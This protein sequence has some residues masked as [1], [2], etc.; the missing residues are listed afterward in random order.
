MDAEV[1][2]QSARYGVPI[3][4]ASLPSAGATSPAT[5]DG[6]VLLASIEI[7]AQ[8]VMSQLVKP[9]LP[10]YGFPIFFTLDMQSGRTLQSSVES[11]LGAAATVQFINDAFHIPTHTYGFGTD[12]HIPDGQSTIEATLRSLLVSMADCDILGGAGQLDV[13]TAFSPVQLIIDDTLTSILKR[14]SSGVKVD[15]DTLA[16]R[17]ILDT[18]PIGHFLERAHTLKYCREA[19]RPE[20][21]V[22][23]PMELWSTEG[24]KD[25]NTRAVEKYRE[26]KKGLQP[27]QLPEDVQKELDRIVKQA[28]ERLVK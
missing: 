13:A 21:L 10:V 24:S 26:L 17:D 12:S 9:G 25:L 27:Q 1:I 16:W 14:I 7:L 8:L 3:G 6:T 4:L 18:V 19:L 5:I 22:S 28:D 23:Q 15:D 2:I 11:I 20:L